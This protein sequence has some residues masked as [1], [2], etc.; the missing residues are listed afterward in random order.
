MTDRIAL[1]TEA[2]ESSLLSLHNAEDI[3]SESAMIRD[4]L[5]PAMSE[6]RVVCD[7]AE[8]LT[9]KSYWPF[10]T[11]ADLLFGVK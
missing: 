3:I 10:P 4:K 8:T 6:L 5:L 9:A 1:K 2:L 11:Y 7:E